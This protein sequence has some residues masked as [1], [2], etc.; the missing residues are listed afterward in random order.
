MFFA[1]CPAHSGNVRSNR[2][3][4]KAN[5]WKGR[6]SMLH[7]A[8]IHYEDFFR[9]ATGNTPFPYQ[10]RLAETPMSKWPDLLEIPTGLGKTAAVVLAWIF[11]R[12][13]GDPDAPRRLV[14]TLPTRV[15]VEQTADSIE[16]WIRNI[17]PLIQAAPDLPTVHRLMGGDIDETWE[18]T[19]ERSAVLVG[20]QDQLLS[21][22]LCRGYAMS[23][24][25]WPVHFG[26]LN[27]DCLWV[28]DEI[29]L[30]GPG[31][32]T[33][34]QLDAFRRT[35]GT[36][37]PHRTLWMS[38]TL[39]RERLGTVDF[40]PRLETLST[41]SLTEEDKRVPEV[42]KRTGAHKILKKAPL[43]GDDTKAIAEF[44][45]ERHRPGT[46][47]LV[48]VNRVK[49]AQEIYSQLDNIA[50]HAPK[51]GKNAPAVC[52]LHSR[53][54][55]R[56]RAAAFE[57][58]VAEPSGN[59]TIVVAT[60]VIEAG[61]NISSRLMITDIAP[62]SSMVQRFG[63]NARFGEFGPDDPAGI[64]WIETDPFRFAG[65]SKKNA[66]S[67]ASWAAPYET[68][69]IA[70]AREQLE[71]LEGE[72]AAPSRLPKVPE[73][74][75][76]SFVLRRKDLRDF[77]D[78]TPDLTGL[79]TDVSR[80]IR[81]SEE[82]NV[83]VFWRDL[84]GK[85]P[86]SEEPHPERD[87]LCSAP[88]GDILDP[89]KKWNARLW[90]GID[91]KWVPCKRPAPGMTLMLDI[92]NGGYDAT[93]GWTGK[94]SGTPTF[95]IALQE[96]RAE[97]GNDD[98]PLAAGRW[99]TLAEHTDRVVE[100]LRAVLEGVGGLT[101][102]DADATNALMSAARLH[103]VGKAHPVYRRAITDGKTPPEDAPAGTVWAKSPGEKAGKRLRY[104]RPGFR[105]E[106][107]SALAILETHPEGET[108]LND[109]AAYLA[110]AHH[111]KVRMSLRSF[112][113]E[114]RPPDPAARFARGVWD[115]DD[116]T[117]VSLGGGIEFPGLKL[118]LSV[119]ELGEGE[120][121]PSWTARTEALLDTFGPFRLA[122]LEALLRSAD[123]RASASENERGDRR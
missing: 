41:M 64:F 49:R 60:Q 40:A 102:P 68:A 107:A 61:V 84:A 78:T 2:T 11:R 5:D 9:T 43:P 58:A 24:Y 77:F 33:T 94:P 59:G 26:L 46:R 117:A 103:D 6:D 31:L 62:W 81:D 109:L 17:A 119:M 74:F 22:A 52:L 82:L 105:H 23:R 48:V 53:F 80:F 3:E 66:S 18:T 110:A 54:R 21:R 16:E 93:L 88:L 101:M 87:E 56:E 71:L 97:E 44:A 76:Y 73:P 37:R 63:R 123:R 27:N 42:A 14:F 100:E 106:L 50:K 112:P 69:A 83:H 55:P 15:L 122:Y 108:I 121:G 35:F 79:D 29:Q 104:E 13:P 19:P 91:R 20:T 115:G 75:A 72:N 12:F 90:D 98:D 32:A 89:K 111:G 10:K 38:A 4:T 96:G 39:D 1:T 30:M 57:R 8:D 85:Q 34:T 99:S 120:R 113:D 118:D 70:A 51:K 65:S 86:S 67:N 116:L 36:A 28:L 114:K 25:K 95:D 47:T 7:N 45:F 92:A